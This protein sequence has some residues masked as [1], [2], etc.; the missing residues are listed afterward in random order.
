MSRKVLLCSKDELLLGTRARLLKSAGIDSVCAVSVSE[1]EQIPSHIN[2]GLVV[3]GQS[4]TNEE[5]QVAVPIVRRRWPNAK[6]L[7][8]H[9]ADQLREDIK[10]CAYLTTLGS[11][12]E[13]ISKT[14]QM[15]TET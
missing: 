13:F 6:I 2:F 9:M 15:L 11:P 1:F 3:L 7:I 14:L 8:F 10:G 4:L 12:T 5:V